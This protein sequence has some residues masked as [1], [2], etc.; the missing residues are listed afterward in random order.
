MFDTETNTT[1][2]AAEICQLAATDHSGSHIFSQYVLPRNNI[3]P[4]ASAVN[5][6]TVKSVINKRKLFKNGSMLPT[7]DVKEAITKFESYISESITRKF[8]TVLIGHNT[9]DIPILLRNTGEV[10]SNKL[11]MITVASKGYP[12]LIFFLVRASL[13]YSRSTFFYSHFTFLNSRFT[14]L[15]SRSTFLNSRSTFLNSRSTFLNE[16]YP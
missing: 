11:Q 13:F 1:G 10:F 3:D 4:R 15:N 16:E 2:I 12:R 7:L 5:N 6:L 14:F 8:V 9:F